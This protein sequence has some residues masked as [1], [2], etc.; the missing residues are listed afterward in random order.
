M[1]TID[2][3]IESF[4]TRRLKRRGRTK[5]NTQTRDTACKRERECVEEETVHGGRPRCAPSSGAMV[6]TCSLKLG[7]TPEFS[8]RREAHLLY[9]E[10]T[11]FLDACMKRMYSLLTRVSDDE[12]CI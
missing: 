6:C 8:D 10:R 12:E 11:G 1:P 4:E 7:R 9:S 3:L 2:R 5:K